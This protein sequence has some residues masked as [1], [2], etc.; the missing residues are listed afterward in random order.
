MDSTAFSALDPLQRETLILAMI[1]RNGLE[2]F[3]VQH[4]SDSQMKDLSQIVRQS[5]FD[6]LSLIA[7][8]RSLKENAAP[9]AIRALAFEIS[10]IPDY[11]EIPESTS[12]GFVDYN[13]EEQYRRPVW[14]DDPTIGP[15]YERFLKIGDIQ[16]ELDDRDFDEVASLVGHPVAPD[17]ENSNLRRRA[18]RSALEVELRRVVQEILAHGVSQQKLIDA[19]GMLSRSHMRELF[20]A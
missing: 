16:S 13:P 10:L 3:H 6:G 11:W 2:D 1:V 8:I 12:E 19:R 14:A 20:S 4:L 9:E 17:E 5:L 18:A 7:H 15:I